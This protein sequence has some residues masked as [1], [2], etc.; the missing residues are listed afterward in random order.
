MLLRGSTREVA[1]RRGRMRVGLRSAARR[2]ASSQPTAPY[3]RPATDASRLT[4]CLDLDETIVH[5][6]NDDL[7][8]SFMEPNGAE[9]ARE[10]AEYDMRHRTARARLPRL[11]DLEVELPYL[12]E[13]V[14]IHKRPQLDDFL[15][16]ASKMC[17][18]VLFTSAS[19]LYA[20]E[21]V[22]ALDPAGTVFSAVLTRDHCTFDDGLYLK[23]LSKLGRPLERVVCVDDHVGSC[24]LQ[25]SN[26]VPVRPYLGEG[27][28][29]ELA[30][31]LALLQR[32]RN[33]DDVRDSL[34]G[35]YNLQ[36]IML[37]R[38]R[39]IRERDQL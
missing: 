11:P 4:L 16:E 24:M 28:D 7:N 27:D 12:M 36:E 15:L 14:Q 21:C 39:R 23:D 38:V 19:D 20:R 37:G 18:V 8:M 1:Q 32:L 33:V 29:R 9:A 10:A 2:F 35:M 25:P 6:T 22:R 17:E 31:V 13:P 5:S 26:A 30:H 34:R 3:L